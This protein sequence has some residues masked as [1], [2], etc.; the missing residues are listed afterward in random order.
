MLSLGFFL[1]AVVVAAEWPVVL[2]GAL[3][4]PPAIDAS[5][6]VYL[7]AED[8]YLYAF[9]GDGDLEWRFDVAH[10]PAA[11]LCVCPRGAIIVGTR[12]GR[13]TSVSPAGHALWSHSASGSEPRSPYCDSEGFVHVSYANGVVRR[14]SPAG[15][16]VWETRIGDRPLLDPISGP[17]GRIFHPGSGGM[18]TLIN[19]AG[20]YFDQFKFNGLPTAHAFVRGTYLLGTDRGRIYALSQDGAVR[21][22][23]IPGMGTAVSSLLAG[24][25]GRTH[26]LTRDGRLLTYAALPGTSEVVETRQLPF[27]SGSRLVF[28]DD[29]ATFLT[30]RSGIYAIPEGLSTPETAVT[31]YRGRNLV[32]GAVGYGVAVAQ[33]EEW[34]VSGRPLS[35]ERG[36]H[37]S[38]PQ[39]NPLRTGFALDREIVDPQEEWKRNFDYLYLESHLLSSSRQDRLRAIEDLENRVEAGTLRGSVDYVVELL[40]RAAFQDFRGQS[41]GATGFSDLRARVVRLLGQVGGTSAVRDLLRLGRYTFSPDVDAEI[42]RAFAKVPAGVAEGGVRRIEEILRRHAGREGT[43]GVGRAAVAAV[44]AL[45]GYT[46]DVPGAADIL[47]S[48]IQG[49]YPR[50]VREHALEVIQRYRRE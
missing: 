26:V 19:A 28:T 7:L 30:G 24:P 29:R 20:T 5:G 47:G 43:D 6:R 35:T 17:R 4:A 31:S 50:E 41:A 22:T 44:E 9:S 1:S 21:S 49:A 15:T 46:G 33:S 10:L 37:W 13:I 42:L 18:V 16:L 32:D 14:F 38:A 48:I 2:G 11:S 34:I 39:G 25:G 8:R 45:L 36:E 3:T 23:Q 12:D 40:R 27:G